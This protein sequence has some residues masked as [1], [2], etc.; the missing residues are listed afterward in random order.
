MSL[1]TTAFAVHACPFCRNN[2]KVK[3]E[4]IRYLLRYSHV[5]PCNC[6]VL[7]KMYTSQEVFLALPEIRGD[8][9]VEFRLEEVC[10]EVGGEDY[11]VFFWY[12]VQWINRLRVKVVLAWRQAVG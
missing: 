9:E 12:P 6:G 10:Y 2:V 5:S 3:E 4:E 8:K 1:K 7:I 11:F